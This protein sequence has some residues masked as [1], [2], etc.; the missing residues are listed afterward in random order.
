[1]AFSEAYPC[2]TIKAYNGR[3]LLAFLDVCMENLSM[4]IPADEPAMEIRNA[5]LASR[6]MVC[7]FDRVERN[8]YF[9]TQDQ[10]DEIFSFGQMYLKTFVRLALGALR[11]NKKR[12]KYQPKLHVYM[13]LNEDMKK[14]L[15]NC[16]A[17]HCFRDE[18]FVGVSKKLAVKVH[19]GPL[20]ESR[21]LTSWQLR[22][23]GWKP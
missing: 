9:L 18:D 5:F 23:G 16:R 4:R 6:A 11:G 3:L 19:K 8:G 13:H 7:W 14:F 12:W 22:L 10:A 15:V 2:L 17:Y 21:I 20:F 1:M